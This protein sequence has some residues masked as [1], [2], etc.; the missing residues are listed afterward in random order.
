MLGVFKGGRRLDAEAFRQS[1]IALP[2]SRRRIGKQPGARKAE[3][4]HRIPW[5]ALRQ[6]LVVVGRTQ[7]S[8]ASASP[9]ATA[10]ARKAGSNS[11]RVPPVRQCDTR[12]PATL[13]RSREPHVPSEM[14]AADF[15]RPDRPRTSPRRPRTDGAGSA[16]GK[17]RAAG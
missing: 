8:V 16:P 14:A 4:K 17:A 9:I 5:P 15:H 11:L 1:R 12:L 6:P 7:A 2:P 13:Q 10:F 3:G